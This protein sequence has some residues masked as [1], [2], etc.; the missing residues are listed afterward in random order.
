MPSVEQTGSRGRA[1]PMPA[2]VL[3]ENGWQSH[4]SAALPLGKGARTTCTGGWMGRTGKE[5]GKFLT[6]TGVQ[7]LNLPARS[8]S[9]I[10]STSIFRPESVYDSSQRKTND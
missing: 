4:D 1:L 6:P 2:S 9:L 7:T 10:L 3:D 5:N 8:A